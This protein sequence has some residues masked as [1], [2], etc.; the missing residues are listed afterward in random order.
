ML[1]R[2][3]ILSIQN[4][5]VVIIKY[6]LISGIHGNLPALEAVIEDAIKNNVDQYVFLGDYCISLAYPNEVLNCIF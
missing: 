1:T 3:K 4:K 6:A 2:G 5:G